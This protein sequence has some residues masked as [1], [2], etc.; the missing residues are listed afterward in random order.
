MPFLTEAQRRT[1]FAS[2]SRSNI[3]PTRLPARLLCQLRSP[4]NQSNP[5]DEEGAYRPPVNTVDLEFM[6]ARAKSAVSTPSNADPFLIWE[7]QLSRWL[8]SRG[9]A[10]DLIHADSN[11]DLSSQLK[12]GVLLGRLLEGLEPG[13][14]LTGFNRK[15]RSR[16][17]ALANLEL[18]LAAVWRRAPLARDM[19]SA[20]EV[21]GTVLY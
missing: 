17:A 9:L 20:E 4:V 2:I 15:A 7:R 8:G 6:E 1:I 13:L 5:P 11:P 14:R 18:V 10:L 16:A 3:S 19:P 21:C 12:D